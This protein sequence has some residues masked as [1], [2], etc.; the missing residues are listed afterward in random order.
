[1]KVKSTSFIIEK[2]FLQIFAHDPKAPVIQNHFVGFHP[3]ELTIEP[4]CDI[5]LRMGK[6][7]L[8]EQGPT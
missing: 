1:V 4:I 7:T 2:R 6:I 5:L 8:A 3:N